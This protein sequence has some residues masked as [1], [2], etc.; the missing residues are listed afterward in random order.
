[1]PQPLENT[2]QGDTLLCIPKTGRKYKLFLCVIEDADF[3]SSASI[4][5]PAKILLTEKEY[6][7]EDPDVFAVDVYKDYCEQQ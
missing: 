5:Y 4:Y 2:I 6:I 3:Y 7:E 1:M